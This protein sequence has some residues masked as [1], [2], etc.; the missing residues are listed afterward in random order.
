ME[1]FTQGTE[2]LLI[3]DGVLKL[4]AMA[5]ARISKQQLFARLRGRKIYTITKVTRLYM[6]ACGLFSIYT[7]EEEKPGLSVLPDTDKEVHSI[8]PV[9]G[10][11]IVACMNC[12]N[13][14]V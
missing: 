12:G 6:E 7:D 8:Q 14:I 11:A 10:P 1:E 3:E 9:A 4:D 2:S 13:T 5:E